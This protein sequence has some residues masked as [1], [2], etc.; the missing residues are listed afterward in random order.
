MTDKEIKKKRAKMMRLLKETSEFYNSENRGYSEEE[1]S[2]V[3]LDVDTGNKC[4][5]GRKLRQPH[6]DLIIK[7]DLQDASVSHLFNH[8][9]KNN[10]KL[11]KSLQGL[12]RGFLTK[13]QSFHDDEGKYNWDKNGLTEKGKE[14]Y[15][16]IRNQ[17]YKGIYDN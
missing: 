8:F 7:E 1:A 6:Y 3:Y 10:L 9:D 5:I 15:L 11:P 16:E 12:S 13:L 17:I 14:E 4:A 2:C